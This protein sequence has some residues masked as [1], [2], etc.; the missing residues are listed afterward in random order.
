MFE[1]FQCYGV[2]QIV[3]VD[4]V[5]EIMMVL[6]YW[7]VFGL[8]VIVVLVNDL[9]V[10]FEVVYFIGFGV[11]WWY[12]IGVVEGFVVLVM[13]GYY[14]QLVDD[15]YQ[16]VVVVGFEVEFYFVFGQCFDFVYVVVI[17]SVKGCVF[18]VQLFK[19]LYYVFGVYWVFIGEVGLFVQ[20][21][22]DLVLVFGLFDG[23]SE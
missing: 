8:V 1:G 22:N 11:W 19:V 15:Y 14:W 3:F 4:D 23:F 13:F 21:E 20:G 9:F 12:Q 17:V 2:V 18:I 10:G 7:Q 6:V 5:V 16:F